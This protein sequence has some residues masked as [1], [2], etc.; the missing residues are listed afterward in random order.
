MIFTPLTQI[1]RLSNLINIVFCFAAVV[2]ERVRIGAFRP[3]NCELY[4]FRKKRVTL[5][6]RL[7]MKYVT[8]YYGVQ[9]SKSS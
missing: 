5:K 7:L 9:F 1:Y 3:K 6:N 8:K 2:F 4:R